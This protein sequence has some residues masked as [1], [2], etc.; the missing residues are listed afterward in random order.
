M[1]A[2]VS[3]TG[4]PFWLSFGDTPHRESHK[5]PGDRSGQA[6]RLRLV[7]FRGI[8]PSAI[9]LRFPTPTALGADI[10]ATARVAASRTWQ[11]AVRERVSRQR[12]GRVHTAACWSHKA[13]ATLVAATPSLP[14]AS[15]AAARTCH[16]RFG[17][18]LGSM[19]VWAEEHRGI[20]FHVGVGVIC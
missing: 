16:D 8:C 3:A 20:R 5:R 6:L 18:P 14:S 13:L 9:S 15:H 10:A 12:I 4:G 7:A 19:G 1:W 11:Q 17:E 2:S